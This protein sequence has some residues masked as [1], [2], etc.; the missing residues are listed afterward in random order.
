MYAQLGTIRFEGS[1]G[2]SSLEESFAV[3]YA[4]HERIKSKPRL[5][6]VGDVLDTISFEMLLH[7]QFTDPEADIAIL[8]D[9][10]QNGEI[11]PLILGTGKVLGNFVIP[12][13]TKTTEFTDPS[14]N[15]ISVSLSVELLES[16]SEDPLR[17]SNDQAKNSAFATKSRN[18]E[19]RSI[20][21]PK[22]SPATSL[23]AD[24][25]KMETSGLKIEQH[26]EA[27]EKNPATFE[28]YSGKVSQVLK[29]IEQNIT[30]V[31]TAI[32]VSQDL[33][34]GAPLLPSALQGVY[35]SVQNITGI[36]PISDINSFKELTKQL[37]NSISIVQNANINNS[38]Q[39]IIR[40]K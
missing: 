35:T 14:G 12:S 15:L 39:S 18:S 30:N 28:Y 37:R 2:F 26:A 24:I 7:S 5:E 17:E 38:N 19:V 10:M 1:K 23:T 16:F 11:L 22:P 25:S 6:R 29:Q 27:A 8:R 32:S 36:L 40:R 3:N 13:F 34:N 4:Q 9:Y 31:Q 21:P 33:S 20:I